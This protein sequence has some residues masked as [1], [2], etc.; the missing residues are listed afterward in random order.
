[1]LL[2]YRIMPILFAPVPQHPHKAI[3]PFSS[4]ILLYHPVAFEAH[5]PVKRK[6]E[7]IKGLFSLS[8]TRWF[9]ERYHA[10]L[11]RMKFQLEAVETFRQSLHDSLYVRLQLK[12]HNEIIGKS[13]Q[14]TLALHTGLNALDEPVVQHV[15]QKDITEHRRYDPALG[16]AL[17]GINDLATFGY[18]GLQPLA[19]QPKDAA[20]VYPQSHGLPQ[21]LPVNVVE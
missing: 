19:D 20:I 11:F 18:P 21:K 15:V 5:A 8:A 14:E 16:S 7:K 1:M 3:S 6:P 10:G 9:T 4:G 12:T 13:N 2:P 17:F